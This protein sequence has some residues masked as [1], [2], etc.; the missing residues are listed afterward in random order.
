MGMI[1]MQNRKDVN[2]K[3]WDDLGLIR[4][5]VVRNKLIVHKFLSKCS[6]DSCRISEKKK[7]LSFQELLG[8]SRESGLEESLR[9]DLLFPSNFF[10]HFSQSMQQKL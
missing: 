3:A 1:K 7:R 2:F 8:I 4:R 6:E 9:S 5:R 10:F